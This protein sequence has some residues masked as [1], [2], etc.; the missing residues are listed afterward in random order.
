[1]VLLQ[2]RKL[3][4]RYLSLY[5]LHN[6]ILGKVA[7]DRGSVLDCRVVETVAGVYILHY[8]GAFLQMKYSEFGLNYKKLCCAD[9]KPVCEQIL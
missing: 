5:L 9:K 4:V 2:V 6:T 3:W 1:M 8:I 7:R